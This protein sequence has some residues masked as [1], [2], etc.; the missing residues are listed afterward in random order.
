[1]NPTSKV[2]V[3][4]AAATIGGVWAEHRLYPGLK[5][6]NQYGTYEYSDFPME[7]AFGVKPGEHIPGKV[8]HEYLKKYAEFFGVD[9]RIRFNTKVESAEK[10]DTSGGWIIKTS[11]GES[12]K[13]D[14]FAMSF[15][16]TQKLV[17][18]TGMTSQPFMPEFAGAKEFGAPIFHCKDMKANE[19]SVFQTAKEVVVLGGTKS[20]WDAAHAYATQGAQVH[21][22]VRESGRGPI[23]MVP[24]NLTPLKLRFEKIPSVRFLTWFSPCVWGE[25]DGFGGIRRL[26]HNT[27]IGRWIV[28]TFWAILGANLASESGYKG[29]V[30]TEKLKP[31]TKPYYVATSLSLLNYPTDF[32]GLVR[33]GQIKVH[34]ADI[35]HLSPG[36]V[37]LSTGESLKSDAIICSTGWK[38]APPIKFLPEGCDESLGLPCPSDDIEERLSKEAD[39]AIL[40]RFPSLKNQPARSSKYKPLKPLGDGTASPEVQRPYRLYRFMVPPALIED[41]TIAFVGIVHTINTPLIAQAQALWLTAYLDGDLLSMDDEGKFDRHDPKLSLQDRVRQET[42]LQTQYGKWRY[43]GSSKRYPDFIFDCI[44]YLD[45]LL[46]DLGLPQHRKK[47]WFKECFTPY[48]Q[49][50]YRGLVE[51][52]KMTR[53]A[54]S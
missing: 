1:V 42:M 33:K 9:K 19:D 8:V 16:R 22:V 50:D 11:S 47:S 41:R 49:E 3:V 18:A 5:T 24:G 14:N 53:K 15:L 28:S 46:S 7:A 52:W 4:E 20:G 31:W 54:E 36:T 26:L 51:E 39:T 43:P 29:H 35:D 30:E 48:G 44:P 17:V 34:I 27:I 23:W 12:E 2:L 21:L 32:F 37:D 38:Y 25:Y 10:C 13:N 45:M 40:Q 6:N